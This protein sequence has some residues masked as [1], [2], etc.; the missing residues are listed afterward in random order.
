MDTRLKAMLVPVPAV[1]PVQREGMFR[2]L[3]RY[4]ENVTKADFLAD[5][6]EKQWVIVLSDPRTGE[7]CG[8][9]TQMLMRVAVGSVS[10]RALFSGDTVVAREH[11]GDIALARTWGRLAL[12]LI[13][14]QDPEEFYWFLISK[15][16]KTYRFLPLFFHEFYPRYDA[17][18]PDWAGRLIHGLAGH[19]YAE[20]Y[21]PAAGIIR[22]GSQKDRLRAGIADLTAERLRDPH[23]RYFVER[24]PGYCLG[25][26]LCCLAPLSRANFTA[27]AY[28]VIGR[29][30]VA[31]GGLT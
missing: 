6:A 7:L 9:S 24:N 19:K 20:A 12:S 11:W 2:L 27:A 18:T 10:V 3:E 31:T 4:Y 15:G 17:P 22:G 13:D 21:D 8:F 14:Q 30:P 26:E 29:E 5:L 1:T 16:Y 28:R 23:V 25:E